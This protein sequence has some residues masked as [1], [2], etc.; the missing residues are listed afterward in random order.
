[1][2]SIFIRLSCCY[3]CTK[4]Y[5]SCKQDVHS[6]VF[7]NCINLKL[8]SA[9]LS[10]PMTS[11]T[12][13]HK[14]ELQDRKR[15]DEQDMQIDPSRLPVSILRTCCICGYFTFLPLIYIAHEKL[16]ISCVFMIFETCFTY[17]CLNIFTYT[18]FCILHGYTL[19]LI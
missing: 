19:H 15:G 14:I 1:M 17:I 16:Y 5:N 7:N 8:A 10:N 6:W 9:L 2:S 4:L 12:L 11:S 3:F 13:A 18:R